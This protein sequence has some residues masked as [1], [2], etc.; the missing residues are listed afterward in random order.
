[1]GLTIPAPDGK[2]TL[3]ADYD[4]VI[5][6]FNLDNGKEVRRFEGHT[7]C[8]QSLVFSADGRYILSGSCDGTMRL[9]RWA[10]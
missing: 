6:L 1:M 10:K 5:R 3:S 7:G 8:I 4:N 9:W 2:G